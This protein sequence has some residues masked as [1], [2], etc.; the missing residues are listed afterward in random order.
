MPSTAPSTTPS[1]APSTA[2]RTSPSTSP[3]ELP[4]NFPSRLPSKLPSMGPTTASNWPSIGPTNLRSHVPSS[5]PSIFPSYKPSLTPSTLPSFFPS[6]LPTLSPSLNPSFT[7]S[8][9]PSFFP[10]VAPTVSPSISPTQSPSITPSK[11]PSKFSTVEPSTS[12]SVTSNRTNQPIISSLPSMNVSSQPTFTATNPIQASSA[13]PSVTVLSVNPSHVPSFAESSRP[14]TIP[15]IVA[16]SSTML[17]ILMVG[18]PET[19]SDAAISVFENTLLTY[20]QANSQGMVIK[21]VTL[22]S[23]GTGR[24]RLRTTENVGSIEFRSLQATAMSVK[25]HVTANTSQQAPTTLY[26]TCTTTLSSNSN[27]IVTDLRQADASF[28]TLE[29]LVSED[30]SMMP[31]STPSQSSAPILLSSP[32]PS[33]IPSDSPSDIILFSSSPTITSWNLP[34]TNPSLSK[35]PSSYPSIFPTAKPSAHPTPSPSVYPSEAP[36]LTPPVTTVFSVPY[37]RSTN[38]TDPEGVSQNETVTLMQMTE[39]DEALMDYFLIKY[40]S[41]C[42]IEECRRNLNNDIHPFFIENVTS[43]ITN[44]TNCTS[45]S[46]DRNQLVCYNIDTN[47]TVTRYPVMFPQNRSNLIVLTTVLGFMD[48][49]HIEYIPLVPV[50]RIVTTKLSITFNG[51]V[52]DEMDEDQTADFVDTLFDF[53]EEILG[54]FEPPI[55]VDDVIFDHQTL[56]VN[57]TGYEQES[58]MRLLRADTREDY[59]SANNTNSTESNE[60]TIVVTVVGEYLPPPDIDF[61]DIV[62]DAFDEEGQEDFIVAIDESDNAYFEPVIDKIS[63]KS[64]ATVNDLDL[65]ASSRNGDSA[66]GSLGVTGG[67]IVVVASSVFTV[68]VAALLWRK[69]ARIILSKKLDEE[70]RIQ[71]RED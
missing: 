24:R 3:S 59:K 22:L 30:T 64:V 58:D 2:P 34:S 32:N 65:V 19:L 35:H 36:S 49:R 62:I 42:T 33:Q 28:S 47:V 56:S 44:T 45:N 50:P 63:V 69:R 38:M 68:I 61:D 40:G 66:F 31:S 15:S 29:S 12:P 57:V 5:Q 21:S 23:I 60:L 26:A 27:N 18:L 71:Y 14:S 39:E 1:T 41:N 67:V 37:T 7:P 46:V 53:L 25:V 20:F 16:S 9:L 11:Y 54:L 8:T 10:S 4:S 43:Y 51:V 52:N 17:S 13:L 6:V 55:L 70:L 48:E